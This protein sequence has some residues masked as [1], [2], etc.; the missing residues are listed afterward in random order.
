M[1]RTEWLLNRR[2]DSYTLKW[3]MKI[4]KDDYDKLEAKL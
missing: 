4:T 3:A 2:D 1:T